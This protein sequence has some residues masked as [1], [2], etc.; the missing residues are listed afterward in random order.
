MIDN[1][2]EG[3][4]IRSGPRLWWLFLSLSWGARKRDYSRPVFL[5]RGGEKGGGS[6]GCG[7]MVVSPNTPN[8]PAAHVFLSPLPQKMTFSAIDVD[9]M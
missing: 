6:G 2:G 5:F 9:L 7:E 3:Q 8:L 1:R 4:H